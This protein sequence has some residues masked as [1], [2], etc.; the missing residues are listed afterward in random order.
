MRRLPNPRQRVLGA[1]DFARELDE[2]QPEFAGDF[3]DGCRGAV[4]EDGPV[5]DPF[6]EGVG[7]EDAAEEEDGLFGGVPVLV[8]VAGGY[9]RPTRIFCCGLM[10]R[11]VWFARF[12][13]RVRLVGCGRRLRVRG[14]AGT[15]ALRGVG[16]CVDWHLIIV[17]VISACLVVTRMALVRRRSHFVPLIAREI[18][19]LVVAIAIVDVSRP[20]RGVLLAV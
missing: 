6:A 10:G 11:L 16:G 15:C 8:G 14:A 3:G 12:R 17:A 20:R 19:L 7:V 4:V 5:V 9:A 2:Q 13:V 18:L 1:L